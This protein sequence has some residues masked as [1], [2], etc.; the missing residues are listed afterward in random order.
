MSATESLAIQLENN[1]LL[2]G[3]QSS[4]VQAVAAL[5][6]VTS[7]DGG[8][9]IVRQFAQD[10]DVM[11]LLEG[12]ARIN[13]FSGDLIAEAGPGSVIGEMSLIDDQPRSATV[14]T[15]G[16]TKVAR[17][18]SKLLWALMEEEPGIAKVLLLNISRILA[19]RLR[20]ANVHLDL[21]AGR[22]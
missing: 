21:V 12:K 7:H 19:A 8:V 22:D 3:L 2:K 15:M 11:I 16:Q 20:A 17:I 4:Q 18:K 6:E 14:V 9:T 1:Y 10:A 5:A 13:T